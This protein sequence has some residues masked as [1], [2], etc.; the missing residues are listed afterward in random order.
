MRACVR[1][2]LKPNRLL[3]R[4]MAKSPTF[5]SCRQCVQPR[6]QW[7]LTLFNLLDFCTRNMVQNR[8]EKQLCDWLPST[9]LWSVQKRTV[10]CKCLET[11]P[12]SPRFAFSTLCTLPTTELSLNLRFL[13]RAQSSLSRNPVSQSASLVYLPIT[14]PGA[15]QSAISGWVTGN[16]HLGE[17]PLIAPNLE[18]GLRYQLCFPVWSFFP[19]QA[20]TLCAIEARPLSVLDD[21]VW[22]TLHWFDDRFLKKW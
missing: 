2:W 21:S 22:G 4:I 3:P 16:P 1:D 10:W 11:S 7:N 13:E 8:K 5:C 9:I 6:T 12:V 17:L 20:T 14:L 18:P 15:G 19:P